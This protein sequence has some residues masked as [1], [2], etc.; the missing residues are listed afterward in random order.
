MERWNWIAILIIAICILLALQPNI[1]SILE[2]LSGGLGGLPGWDSW[3]P[4]LHS[5]DSGA[6]TSKPY[7][8]PAS[9]GAY[10]YWKDRPKSWAVEHSDKRIKGN[11]DTVRSNRITDGNSEPSP[12]DSHSVSLEYYHDP[13]GYCKRNPDRYPCPNYWIPKKEKTGFKGNKSF[14]SDDMYVPGM[15]SGV[16]APPSAL[17]PTDGGHIRLIDPDREDHGLCGNTI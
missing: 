11:M 12:T 10:N 2:H 5:Y 7:G 1:Q 17:E 9:Q 16:K 14:V 15:I 4:N 8:F 3:S 13:V 6:L